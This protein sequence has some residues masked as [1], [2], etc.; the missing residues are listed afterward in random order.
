MKS[1]DVIKIGSVAVGISAVIKFP[2]QRVS[3]V[4]IAE[5][6]FLLKNMLLKFVE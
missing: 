2:A 4:I 3:R 5:E 6:T 1:F